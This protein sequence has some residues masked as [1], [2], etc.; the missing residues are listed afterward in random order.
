VKEKHGAQLTSK[1]AVSFHVFVFA[2]SAFTPDFSFLLRITFPFEELA[3]RNRKLRTEAEAE[4]AKAKQIT[5][6]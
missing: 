1:S 2:A 6:D 5:Y 4:A 3:I